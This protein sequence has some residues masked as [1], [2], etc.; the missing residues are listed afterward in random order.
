MNNKETNIFKKKLIIFSKIIYILNFPKIKLKKNL[1]KK[2][3][4]F[5][6][7]EKINTD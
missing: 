7:F 2:N 1:L 4:N 6:Y 5:L 3:N